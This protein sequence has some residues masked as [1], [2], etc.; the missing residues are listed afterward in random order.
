MT[1]H[2]PAGKRHGGLARWGTSLA[3]VVV[4]VIATCTL[5]W[6][7]G[8]NLIPR[9]REAGGAEVVARSA[10]VSTAPSVSWPAEQMYPGSS[11]AVTFDVTNHSNVALK[12]GAVRLPSATPFAA[13]FRDRSD[14]IASAGCTARNSGVTWRRAGHASDGLH[15]LAVPLTI[16][17]GQTRRF[18]ITNAATMSLG[19]PA[20]CQGAFFVMPPLTSISATP[21]TGPVGSAPVV[22]TWN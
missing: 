4:A 12:M 2:H 9:A 6:A 19:S 7:S 17:A 5:A 22:D 11:G 18:T 21:T 1:Y 15:R 14:T 3:G 20:A 8:V 16:G 13:A 10:V